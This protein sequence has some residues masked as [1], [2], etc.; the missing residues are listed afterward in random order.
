MLVTDLP[1]FPLQTVLF[2]GGLLSL[3]VFEARY[4]D[5]MAVCLR[6]SRPFG[7]VAL[8]RASEV[9]AHRRQRRPRSHRR[10]R[11]VDRCR[12][13]PARHP[14]GALPRHA[15][16]CASAA[17]RQQADGL[18]LAQTH[19]PA[20]RRR[21]WPRRPISSTPCAAWRTP[22]H[23]SRPRAHSPFCAA[24]PFRPRRLGGQPL[25]RDPA[26]LAGRQ[27]E[28]DG[29]ARCAGAAPAGGRI[30]AQQGR[31]EVGVAAASLAQS[32]VSSSLRS[33][34]GRPIANASSWTNQRPSGQAAVRA[35]RLARRRRVGQSPAARMQRPVEVRQR[36]G[37][38]RQRLDRSGPVRPGGIEGLGRIELRQ[39]PQAWPRRRC[40][41]AA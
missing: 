2:P 14:A 11:R 18:W 39:A 31:G 8:R 17:T 19:D 40:R 4:L 7:V 34:A 24:L 32:E 26:D 13:R 27:A 6:E 9:R 22:S 25:V 33:G 12:Q 28:A 1:L 21:R 38:A 41:A 30:P 29:V 10:D 3:K 5:L 20:R 23:R 16:L 15:A 37:E 36:V 35:S